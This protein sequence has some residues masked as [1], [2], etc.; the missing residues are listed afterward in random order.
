VKRIQYELHEKLEHLEE[1]TIRNMLVNIANEFTFILKAFSD[2]L[3]VGEF[4]KIF[5]KNDSV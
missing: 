3:T 1:A 2:K 5:L 4:E